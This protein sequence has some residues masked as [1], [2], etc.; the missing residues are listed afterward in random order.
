MRILL[1]ENF[2]EVTLPQDEK[3]TEEVEANPGDWN[4]IGVY[5]WNQNQTRPSVI[6]TFIQLL[7]ITND[8]IRVK[9]IN[10]Q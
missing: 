5:S 9:F 4:V 1:L 3:E 10:G 7:Y 2:S 8:S 6:T